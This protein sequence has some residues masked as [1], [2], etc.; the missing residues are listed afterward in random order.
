MTVAAR[1][2]AAAEE[3]EAVTASLNRETAMFEA[4][5]G[6]GKRLNSVTVMN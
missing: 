2:V 5:R 3:A 6:R 1:T 4:G